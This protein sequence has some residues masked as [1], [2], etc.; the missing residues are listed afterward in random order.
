MNRYIKKQEK[1]YRFSIID[2]LVLILLGALIFFAVKYFTAPGGAGGEAVELEYT[3]L[4]KS[5]KDDHLGRIK[6]GDKITETSKLCDIGEVA[7]LSYE[8]E[9]TTTVNRETGEILLTENPGYVSV[10]ITV[11]TKAVVE[12]GLYYVN[13]KMLAVGEAVHFRTPSFCN[14]GYCAS[15]DVILPEEQS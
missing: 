14:S 7:G 10:T 8:R 4:I 6:M 1:K 3:I 5:I 15:L 9:K 2:L 11:H 13:G 12:D